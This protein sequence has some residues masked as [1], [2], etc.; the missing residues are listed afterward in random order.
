MARSW[1][2]DQGLNPHPFQWKWS[3]NRWTAREM[4]QSFDFKDE[5]FVTYIDTSQLAEGRGKKFLA[6]LKLSFSDFH[7]NDAPFPL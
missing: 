1:F 5:K 7:L 4:S 2:P 6:E 3:L